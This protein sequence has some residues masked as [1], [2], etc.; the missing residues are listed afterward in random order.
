VENLEKQNNDELLYEYVLNEIEENKKMKGIWAKALAHSDG[1]DE[2]AKSL[3]MQ[4]RV[5]S[6][7]DKFATLGVAYNKLSKEKLFEIINNNFEEEYEKFNTIKAKKIQKEEEKYNKIGGFLSIFGFFL[8]IVSVLYFTSLIEYF[9]DNFKNNLELLYANNQFDTINNINYLVYI[10]TFRLFMTLLLLFSFFNRSYITKSVVIIYFLSKLIIVPLSIYLI[11]QIN[12]E[13]VKSPET[14]KAIGSLFGSLLWALI[15]LPYF[16]FSKRVKKT[17]AYNDKKDSD[18]KVGNI[19][20]ISLFLTGIF[21][22]LISLVS[23]Q[24]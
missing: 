21:F 23:Q 11:Y 12:P 19:I 18:E 20:L 14:S 13:F 15:L 6:I 5:E 7:Q 2:K 17:F 16:I 22:L 24:N 8:L 4:Y 3:Y 9:S 10:D 1:N